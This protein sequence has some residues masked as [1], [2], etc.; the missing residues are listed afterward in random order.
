MLALKC[1]TVP[2]L[3]SRDRACTRNTV[4]AAPL[5]RVL[6]KKA[7]QIPQ[8]V[9]SVVESLQYFPN[10]GLQVRGAHNSTET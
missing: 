4:I 3:H 7:S 10:T 2:I 5:G 6:H 1:L 9:Y 8:P